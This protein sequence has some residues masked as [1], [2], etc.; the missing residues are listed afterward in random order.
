MEPMQAEA[1][2]LAIRQEIY[3]RGA[4]DSEIPT[5]DRLLNSLRA[6]GRTPEDA[7][8]EAREIMARKADYH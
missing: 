8:Q 7:V 1:E 4:N 3:M 6:G 5:I 2:I